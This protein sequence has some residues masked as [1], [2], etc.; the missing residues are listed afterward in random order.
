MNGFGT[1]GRNYSCYSVPGKPTLVIRDRLSEDLRIVIIAVPIAISVLTFVIGVCLICCTVRKVRESWKSLGYSEEYKANNM[2]YVDKR[3]WTAISVLGL[4]SYIYVLTRPCTKSTKR[5]GTEIMDDDVDLSEE[6]VEG[7]SLHSN[8][9]PNSSII[10]KKKE[11]KIQ[12][13]ETEKETV[14]V[15]SSESVG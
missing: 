7:V 5:P 12:N 6:D 8:G 13:R 1:S 14:A 3:C 2:K 4:A 15:D 10:R 11:G 9:Q